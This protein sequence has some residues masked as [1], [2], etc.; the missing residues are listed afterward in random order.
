MLDSRSKSILYPSASVG[1][2]ESQSR[3]KSLSV[4]FKLADRACGLLCR[5]ADCGRR[6]HSETMLSGYVAGLG[7]KNA[8]PRRNVP[9]RYPM[10][11]L[12]AHRNERQSK[13]RGPKFAARQTCDAT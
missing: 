8:L 6:T 4:L 13:E 9:V 2:V 10:S 11:P 12:S 5:A 1:A 3:P 7:M